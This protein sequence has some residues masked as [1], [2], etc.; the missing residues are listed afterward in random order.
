MIENRLQQN[1]YKLYSDKKQ[2]LTRCQFTININ[3]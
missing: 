1:T 2:K 3:W